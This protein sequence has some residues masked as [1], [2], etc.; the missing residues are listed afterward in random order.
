MLLSFGF[1]HA[2]YYL[3]LNNFFGPFGILKTVKNNLSENKIVDQ[4]LRNL[5]KKDS[6]ERIKRN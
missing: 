5:I 6:E 4:D 1:A 2:D 3:G